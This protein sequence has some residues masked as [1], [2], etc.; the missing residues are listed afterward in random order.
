MAFLVFLSTSAGTGVIATDFM[1]GNDWRASFDDAIRRVVTSIHLLR[2][3][4]LFRVFGSAM[5][6]YILTNR[7]RNRGGRG[8]LEYRH[9]V[10]LPHRIEESHEEIE[11]FALILD[12]R[13]TLTIAS[14]SDTLAKV[15]DLVEMIHPERISRSHE[16]CLL[17]LSPSLCTECRFFFEIIFLRLLK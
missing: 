14:K 16:E 2:R 8:D 17:Y 1:S 7:F 4:E 13:I 3:T 6:L 10:I 9:E 15:I 12:E 11:G 5:E